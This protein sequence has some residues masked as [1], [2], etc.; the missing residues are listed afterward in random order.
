MEKSVPS[1]WFWIVHVD[2]LKYVAVHLKGI[3]FILSIRYWRAQRK[4]LRLYLI[5]LY[6]VCIVWRYGC[7]LK[8]DCDNILFLRR[9]KNK[10]HFCT[11]IACVIRMKT[12]YIYWSVSTTSNVLEITHEHK[13]NRLKPN[14]EIDSFSL[15][16]P[17][18]SR[19][20]KHLA[21]RQCWWFVAFHLIK[22][23]NPIYWQN[24]H[25]LKFHERERKNRSR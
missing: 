19:A 10:F 16:G 11:R 14:V 2:L 18:R 1:H 4:K 3:H 6:L 9:K 24:T 7:Y 22:K 12:D 5:F 23:F 25:K 21:S 20:M 17:Q 13:N 8:K 15:N